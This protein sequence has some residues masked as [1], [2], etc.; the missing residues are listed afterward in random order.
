MVKIGGGFRVLVRECEVAS[1]NF[2][3]PFTPTG[4]CKPLIHK[5]VNKGL[6]YDLLIFIH[7]ILLKI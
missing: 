2:L 3:A 5:C 4:G 6:T 1:R 7:I